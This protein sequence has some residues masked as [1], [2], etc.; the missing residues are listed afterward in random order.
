MRRGSVHA[1]AG[2]SAF[3][4]IAAFWTSTVVS[5]LFL[6]RRAVASV[7]MAITYALLVFVP[8]MLVTAASGFAMGG[9]STHPLLVA[10]RRRM[11]IIGANG[12]LVLIPAALFLSIK[13]QAGAFDARFY[14]VQIL[15]LLAGA[16]NLWLMGLNIR[17]GRRMRPSRRLS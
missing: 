14:A 1:F 6:D 10:K 16:S 8:C 9:K 2:V 15:E 11:P 17:D 3:L 5:E 7:K 12:L 4:F 13:A